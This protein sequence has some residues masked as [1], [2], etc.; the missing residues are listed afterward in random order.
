[1]DI[2][3]TTTTTTYYYYYYYCYYYYCTKTTTTAAAVAATATDWNLSKLQPTFIYHS[4]PGNFA[5]RIGNDYKY[6]H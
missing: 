6:E 3:T 4:I 2:T 1:M 5:V